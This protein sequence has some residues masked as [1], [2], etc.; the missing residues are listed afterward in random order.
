MLLLRLLLLTQ[1]IGRGDGQGEGV[2]VRRGAAGPTA[3]GV[4]RAQTGVRE[5]GQCEG[6]RQRAG[7][8]T[9][10]VT[11]GLSEGLNWGSGRDLHAG[12]L[13]SGYALP[14]GAMI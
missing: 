2:R 6:R 5:E 4:W 12:L 8:G 1:G 14:P 13:P 11:H 3:T 9:G 10:R 7:P